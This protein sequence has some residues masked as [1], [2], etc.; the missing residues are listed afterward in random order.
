MNEVRQS[1]RKAG[2][3]RSAAGLTGLTLVILLLF[4]CT[5]SV[6]Q[7][8]EQPPNIVLIFADDLGYGD[9]GNYGQEKIETPHIDSLARQG[10]RFT[11]FY[12]GSPVCAPSR[13]VLLT[14]LH[15]G[16]AYIRGNHEWGERGDVWDYAKAVENPELEG[17]LPV[18]ADTPTLGRL[19]QQA[20][21]RAGIVGK[22]GLGG[23]TSE[24]IP[25]LQGFDFFF[26]FN[27]QRQAH[28]Y[29]PRHL[30][31]NQ[32]K[33]WLDNELVVPGTQLD[34]DADPNDQASYAR[35]SQ[36]QYAPDLM[37]EEALQFI[38]Q[39]AEGP[40]FLY[41]ATPIPHVALQAPQRWVDH[42]RA[43]FGDEEPYIGDRGYLP[44]RYPRAAYAAMISTLD[45]Q[46][47]RIVAKLEE[48]EIRRRTIILFTSDNGPANNGGAD[49]AFF[50]SAHP[51]RSDP[52]WG[53]GSVREGGIRVPLIVDWPGVTPPGSRTDYASALW[54]LFPTLAEAAGVTPQQELDGI[55]LRPV[56]EGQELSWEDR[57]LYWEY[58][59]AGGQQAVRLGDW[60]GLR[61]GIFDGNR[62]V[63]LYNLREDP[64]EEHDV[65]GEH[66]EI[67]R[68]IEEI[69]EREHREP[70]VERFALGAR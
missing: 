39:S 36:N 23:P 27:C 54:D 52:G 21:Y 10:M 3:P 6:E 68:R 31:R 17:Q 13:C 62:E 57:I 51:F 58:P 56:L 2:G 38:E 20:G 49:P 35:F 65:S 67:V 44:H 24:G 4:G 11:Q 12:S 47:G 41:F 8:D 9:L 14:G 15:T 60:K 30:W 26:G 16:H 28:T 59:A 46:V 64:R 1:R 29:Y 5:G 25:N 50:D 61:Q 55:S 53:K 7:V 43:R 66:P 42:Y 18:P 22:W 48:L 45:E 32:E 69:M 63:A 34:P 70:E 19:L 37:I 33:V 40:F